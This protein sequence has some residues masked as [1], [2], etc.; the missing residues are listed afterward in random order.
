MSDEIVL[1]TNPMSR[2]RT[3]RWMLEEVGA[4]YRAEIMEYGPAMQAPPFLAMNPIGKIPVLRH[5]STV[6]TETAGIVAYLADAFPAAALA[7]PSGS[8][9]RGPYYRWLFFGAGVLEAACIDTAMGVTPPEDKQRMAGYGTMARTLDALEA[10]M[11]GRDHLAG[12]TFT[13]A[14]LFIAALLGWTMQ[15]GPRGK[16]PGLPG[17]HPPHVRPPRRRPARRPSTTPSCR[18]QPAASAP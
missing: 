4:P 8:Q 7:P 3:V 15:F 2:G 17:L 1:Y 6:V 9:A 5:G 18:P 16:A 14:D 11:A 13:A 12:D 10:G